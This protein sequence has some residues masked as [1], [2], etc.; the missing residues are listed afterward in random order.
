MNS[1]GRCWVVLAAISF[2]LVV[3]TAQ[4]APAPPP[5]EP[6]AEPSEPVAMPAEEIVELKEFLASDTQSSLAETAFEAPSVPVEVF[7]R[8]AFDSA[9]FV[10]AEEFLQNLPVNNG[11]SVPMQN[12]QTG[13]TPGASSVSLRGLGPGSTLILIN[14][15][16]LAPWP[17]G[18]GGTAAFVDLNSI[19]A[20]AIKRIE[21]IKDGATALYGADAVAGVINIITDSDYD[22]AELTTRYGN[23]F[24]STDSSEFYNSLAFGVGNKRSNI[25]G[26]VFFMQKNSI[27][28]ADR[29]FSATPPFLSSNAIPL[30]MQISAAAA[31]EALGLSP[32]MLIPGLDTEDPSDQNRLIIVTSGPSQPDGTRTS[33]ANI[34]N[35]DGNLAPNQYTYLGSF[36]SHSR[37]NYNRLAQSTPNIERLG[38]YVNFKRK[39][40]NS[41]RITAY[42]DLSF[43]RAK[44][45]NT[46]APT[47]TGNFRNFDG[48]S[49]VIP[50]RT[51]APISHPD[52]NINGA[53]AQGYIKHVGTDGMLDTDDDFFRLSE[54]PAGAF[55]PFNPFN[56]DI[57]GA[58]RIRL[59]EFGLRLI[60]TDARTYYG[61]WG[62]QG[63]DLELGSATWGFDVGFRLSR[64]EELGLTRAV[65]TSRLNRLM[66]AADPW[67]DPSS[68]QYLGTTQPYNPF[69]ASQ[70]DGYWNANNRALS[71]HAL[72]RP[73]DVND[74]EVLFGYANV[75]SSDLYELPGGDLGLAL[76][77]DWRR[78]SIQQLPD[79]LFADG[80]IAGFSTGSPI[81]ASRSIQAFF[82]DTFMPI[83][84][85]EMDAGIHSWNVNFSGRLADFITSG[86][87]TFVPKISSRLSPVKEITLR[88]SWG[89]GFRQPSLFELYYGRVAALGAISNPWN[90][91]DE[92]PEINVT[93][94]GNPNLKPEESESYNVG[95]VYSPQFL[96]NFTVSLDYW[97]IEQV[98][99]VALNVQDTVDRIF[100]GDTVYPGESVQRDAQDNILLVETV[101]LN[102]GFNRTRGID[103]AGNYVLPTENSGTFSWFFNFTWLLEALNQYNSAGPVFDYVG[104]GTGT[105]FALREPQR[106]D[107][108]VGVQDGQPLVIAN[109]GSNEDGY[110]EYKFTASLGWSY[111]NLDLYLMGHYTSGFADINSDFELT[112][113]DSRMLWDM[114]AAYTFFADRA[115]WFANTTV[116]FGIENLFDTDPPAAF[117]YYQNGIGY[118]G[119][120]YEPDGR[121]YY[122]SLKKSF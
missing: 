13:F 115:E 42:G 83:I 14:G 36:G 103:I 2:A 68:S 91:S 34:E 117:A 97:Q 54:V 48:T 105:S 95:F 37:Y 104:Y 93:F 15:K 67:F 58:S 62:F 1:N 49:I 122:L 57:E 29:H 80:D 118:P 24:S 94:A 6:A 44:A 59:E 73:K 10:T 3:T 12:N 69:G 20:A 101:F 16:R 116:S 23:D 77:Y 87:S 98:G 84:G 81:H 18:A 55:N 64:V 47:A 31:R 76:G 45:R 60:D 79:P 108:Q 46:L 109:I 43:T 19:P 90:V 30:N 92:N 39:L 53:A 106:G 112:K 21:V 38:S 56:Q 100:A 11:G 102:S 51:P 22:G 99:T 32:D 78:E 52:S 86:R 66:N 25:T 7:D 120:I 75:S 28:N 9:G 82:F 70:F 17:T 85:P 110:L 74:S 65:S 50:A 41:D 89:E 26:G 72:V 114:Q 4:D 119:A 121:R 63:N 113:I 40:F 61:T 96:K 5:V 35:N 88:G 107:L 71:H 27:Y 33:D 111:R 8:E